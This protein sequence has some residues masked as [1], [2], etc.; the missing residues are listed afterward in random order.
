[1]DSSPAV[2]SGYLYIGSWDHSVYCFNAATGAKIWNYATGAGVF[3]SP[4]IVGGIVYVGS[5]DHRVYAFGASTQVAT[6]F[7]VEIIYIAV[8]IIVVVAIAAVVMLHHK[9]YFMSN[10][11]DIH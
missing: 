9:K 7:P 3:S 5:L 10:K 2:V 11:H 4:A 8:A 1:M 6:A